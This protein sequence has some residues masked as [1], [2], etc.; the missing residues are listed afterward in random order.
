MKYI[1]EYIIILSEIRKNNE[2]IET[3]IKSFQ[4]F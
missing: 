4:F 3:E 2:K 1:I